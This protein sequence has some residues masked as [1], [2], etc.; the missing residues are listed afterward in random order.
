MPRSSWI[1]FARMDSSCRSRK[2]RTYTQQRIASAPRPRAMSEGFQLAPSE[3]AR[4]T[5]EA[6]AGVDGPDVVLVRQVR[7]IQRRYPTVVTPRD[8]RVDDVARFYAIAAR[9]VLE[10]RR[11]LLGD[12]SVVDARRDPVAAGQREVVLDSQV[13]REVG[14]VGLLLAFQSDA[15]CGCRASLGIAR[16]EAWDTWSDGEELARLAVHPGEPGVERELPECGFELRFEAVNRRGIRHVQ[17]EAEDRNRR[18]TDDDLELLVIVVVGIELRADVAIRP[19]CLPADLVVRHQLLV[20][21]RGQ[22]ETDGDVQTARPETGR[23]ERVQEVVRIDG[24]VQRDLAGGVR[25]LGLLVL[26]ERQA[27]LIDQ[28]VIAGVSLGIARTKLQLERV[29]EP[30]RELTEHG[31]GMLR[32]RPF[33]L[34]ASRRADDVELAR[35]EVV[36]VVLIVGAEY[37]REASHVGRDQVELLRVDGLVDLVAEQAVADAGAVQVRAIFRSSVLIAGNG[38]QRRAIAEGVVDLE[39]GAPKAIERV[40]VTVRRDV[41]QIVGRVDGIGGI[42]AQVEIV[43]V[44]LEQHRQAL[45]R[46]PQEAEAGAAGLHAVAARVGTRDVVDTVA[47]LA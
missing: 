28:D 7:A 44:G 33:E 37:P 39:H 9:F 1:G 38:S 27:E 16:A 29:C 5:G 22:A 36:L 11:P 26:H 32:I 8:L 15:R 30:E 14:R 19:P 3:R 2:F 10:Q 21:R 23:D 45:A 41:E 18:E 43:V 6:Q 42:A 47:A 17:L 24:P 40:H 20:E 34:V 35:Q 25:V 31:R 46:R 4:S 12:V 13:E